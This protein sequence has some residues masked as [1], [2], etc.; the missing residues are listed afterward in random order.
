MPFD[1]TMRAPA[2]NSQSLNTPPGFVSGRLAVLGDEPKTA[3][4]PAGPQGSAVPC[5]NRNNSTEPAPKLQARLSSGVGKSAYVLQENV[6]GFCERFGLDRVGFLTLT[7]PDHVVCAREASRRFNSLAGHVLRDRYPA[8]VR[9]LERQKS[10][11]VHFHLLVACRSD[12][13]PGADFDAFEAGDYSSA[14]P[15]LKAEWR[16]WRETAKQYGFGRTEL[17]PVRSTSHAIGRYVGK[18]IG[19]H[20]SAREARDKGVR[21][22][23]Y[24]G[25]RVAINRLSWVSPNA[26]LWRAKK[27]GF[28]RMLHRAGAISAPTDAA[29]S[30]KFG[31]KW[32]HYWRDSIFSFPAESEP[33]GAETAPVLSAPSVSLERFGSARRSRRAP[34][35]PQWAAVFRGLRGR[36]CEL[37]PVPSVL[38]PLPYYG[39]AAFES[40]FRASGS[41]P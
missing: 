23:S 4:S 29:M 6:K 8:Y 19:K 1:T 2:R 27:G 22:V 18:Y 14:S 41:S 28:V 39:H 10:G 31:P 36:G 32:V 26:K 7:F 35:P 12:I 15:A 17:L 38:E 34:I 20:F 25:E 21:L 9:V 16:F 3:L 40:F 33:E 30:A 37:P 5:Q 13:R 11:R 24:S